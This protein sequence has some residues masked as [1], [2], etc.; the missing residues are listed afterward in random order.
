MRSLIIYYTRSGNTGLVAHT[1]KK[2][3]G[4]H[5]REI[6]DFTNN[7]TVLDY[8]FPNLIDSASISPRKVDIDYYET[9]FI[10]TPVWF[11]SLTPAIKKFIDNMDFKNKNVILFN[12]M[13][14]IGGDIAIKRMAKL[15]KKHNGN[16]IG[17]FGIITRGDDYDIMDC[18]RLAIK[19]MELNKIGN[20]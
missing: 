16:V 7:R 19:N 5:V 13:K 8:M 15:V 14:G 20:G 3:L 18:T 6:T 9:I 2:E 11:G 1:I 12:T 17:S 4:A 10:G